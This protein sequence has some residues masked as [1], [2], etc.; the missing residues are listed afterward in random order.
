MTAAPPQ[1]L[2]RQLHFSPVPRRQGR[3]ACFVQI[4]E[5][6]RHPTGPLVLEH[7]PAEPLLQ[8]PTTHRPAIHV[9]DRLFPLSTDLRYPAGKPW[10]T[11]SPAHSLMSRP[12]QLA[13]RRR[14]RPAPPHGSALPKT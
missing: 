4:R 7:T 1:R 2:C 13:L 9:G 11:G 14:G 12:V 10:T 6:G 8:V 5:T 3:P